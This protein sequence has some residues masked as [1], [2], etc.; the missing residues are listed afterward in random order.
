MSAGRRVVM[1]SFP[2][3]KA[4]TMFEERLDFCLI[5]PNDGSE[6][7]RLAGLSLWSIPFSSSKRAVQ[8]GSINR[9]C[10]SVL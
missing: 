6:F 10:T 4:G 1:L 5:A 2:Q 7:A 9:D 3:H 8:T